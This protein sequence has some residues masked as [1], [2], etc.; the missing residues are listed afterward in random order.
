MLR[1]VKGSLTKSQ[2]EQTRRGRRETGAVRGY[3]HRKMVGWS[4]Q[5]VMWCVQDVCL[6]ELH[7]GMQNCLQQREL[8]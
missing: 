8:C 2:T 3:C 6:V 4:E 5:A 7:L 1:T